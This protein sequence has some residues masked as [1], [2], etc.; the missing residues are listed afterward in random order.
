MKHTAGPYTFDPQAPW[1]PINDAE[2]RP[3]AYVA[4]AGRPSAECEANGHLF[5]M[6][7]KLYA[8]AER[9]ACMSK[10]DQAVIDDPNFIWR[11][12]ELA[13]EARALLSIKEDRT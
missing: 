11:L 3:L 10:D 7:D 5:A 4:V 13:D 6:A 9:L 1:S 2:G 12:S 8:F